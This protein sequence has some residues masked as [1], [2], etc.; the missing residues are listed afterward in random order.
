MSAIIASLLEL[1]ALMED[2]HK[3]STKEEDKDEI[4]EE[5]QWIEEEKWIE[6]ERQRM[7]IEEKLLSAEVKAEEEAKEEEKFCKWKKRDS[8]NLPNLPWKKTCRNQ[9]APGFRLIR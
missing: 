3:N 9:N 7:R 5:R 8:E 1:D 2:I 4:E 6:E